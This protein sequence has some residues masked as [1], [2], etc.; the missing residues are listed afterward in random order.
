MKAS[1][2]SVTLTFQ[3]RFVRDAE[4]DDSRVTYEIAVKKCDGLDAI[5]EALDRLRK[6]DDEGE[7]RNIQLLEVRHIVTSD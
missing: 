3:H 6:D 1:V 4:W 7:T 5:N 2:F